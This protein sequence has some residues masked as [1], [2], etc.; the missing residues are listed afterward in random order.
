MPPIYQAICSACNHASPVHPAGYLALILDA[1]SPC[2]HAHPDD[3]RLI[4]L[5]HPLESMILE[6]LGFTLESAAISGRLLY[7]QNVV[8]LGCGTMYELRRLSANSGAMGIS[9]CLSM[10]GVSVGIGFFIGW[11]T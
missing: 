11:Q 7:I 4:I 6:E 3:R 8:C 1:A 5:G 10:F 2:R 9:G